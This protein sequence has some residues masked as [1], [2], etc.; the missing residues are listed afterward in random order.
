MDVP[1]VWAPMKPGHSR[2]QACRGISFQNWA[3]SSN[4]VRLGAFDA[5]HTL[6]NRT[7]EVGNGTPGDTAKRMY[8]YLIR[9]HPQDYLH[10]NHQEKKMF[11]EI[12]LCIKLPWREWYSHYFLEITE[13]WIFWKDPQPGIFWRKYKQKET[14]YYKRSMAGFFSGKSL[15]NIFWYW[16][17]DHLMPNSQLLKN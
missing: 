5:V 10:A 8:V 14:Y 16:K 11:E 4:R 3:G 1:S 2:I 12:H 13:A 17:Q 7:R 6:S 15:P 9:A